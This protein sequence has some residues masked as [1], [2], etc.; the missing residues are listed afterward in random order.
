[1]QTV[2]TLNAMH[3]LPGDVIHFGNSVC[4]VVGVENVDPYLSEG[5]TTL[6][7]E[8]FHGAQYVD[9]INPQRQFTVVR[10]V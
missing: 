7:T 4:F 3:L 1:M 6:V 10:T 5:L 2:L 9:F 8:G